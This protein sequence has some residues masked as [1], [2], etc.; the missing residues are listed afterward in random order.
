MSKYPIGLTGLAVMGEHPVC[1][2]LNH[3]EHG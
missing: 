1:K 2:A 3:T